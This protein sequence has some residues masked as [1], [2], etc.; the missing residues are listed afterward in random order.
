M[1]PDGECAERTVIRE[2]G[3]EELTKEP[4]MR[5]GFCV[6]QVN[7]IFTLEPTTNG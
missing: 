1:L 3:A 4:L 7:E 2:M 5:P 6:S